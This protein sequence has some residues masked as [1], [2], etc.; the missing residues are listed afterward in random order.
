MLSSA[1]SLT[2]L[3]WAGKFASSKVVVI[4]VLVL[5]RL[6]REA[7]DRENL[8][9]VGFVLRHY[10]LG[11]YKQADRFELGMTKEMSTKI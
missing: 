6:Y 7:R 5:V 9:I 2:P 3:Q 1:T 4:L 8:I 10:D 11:L